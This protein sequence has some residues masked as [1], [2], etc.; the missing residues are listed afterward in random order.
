MVKIIQTPRQVGADMQYLVSSGDDLL[1]ISRYL[2]LD[3]DSDSVEELYRTV[4]FEVFSMDW[5]GP[6]WEKVNDLGDRML[7][8]GQNS[9]LSFSASD[10]PGSVG[11]CIY[12][13]DDYSELNYESAFAECDSGIFR[14]SDRSIEG[15]W[16]S[17]SRE[18]WPTPIW[19]SPDPC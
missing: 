10:F 13:T 4:G 17:R 2:D 12:F 8:I 11:N 5:G 9:S 1:L 19:V 16:N 3:Y 6:R 14:L 7:F 15:Q 18:H